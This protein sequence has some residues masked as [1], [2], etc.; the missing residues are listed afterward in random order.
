MESLEQHGQD[1]T[2]ILYHNFVTLNYS[3]FFNPLTLTINKNTALD[4]SKLQIENLVHRNS[5]TQKLLDVTGLGSNSTNGNPVKIASERNREYILI[6]NTSD[7]GGWTIG[8]KGSK[9]AGTKAEPVE[10]DTSSDEKSDEWEEVEQAE[11]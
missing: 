2:N 10:V 4:F 1:G 9:A 7:K 6:K 3:A 5:L 11:K 8:I